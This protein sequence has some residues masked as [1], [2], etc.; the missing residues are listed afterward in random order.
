MIAEIIAKNVTAKASNGGIANPGDHSP[1]MRPSDVSGIAR[2]AMIPAMKAIL[3][4]LRPRCE[5]STSDMASLLPDIF[6]A[7]I[8]HKIE[9]F[10]EFL[11]IYAIA[12]NANKHGGPAT[13]ELSGKS[14]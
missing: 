10:K 11:G 3:A 12:P 8:I 14:S 9:I 13:D 1:A 6:V 2:M 7:C 5:G 4:R